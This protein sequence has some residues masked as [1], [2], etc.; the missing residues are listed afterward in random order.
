MT[1]WAKFVKINY[2][3]YKNFGKYLR[4]K[5]EAIIPK[6]ALNKFANNN[7]IEPAV[8]SRIETLKQDIKLGVLIK[9]A[10]GMG[11]RPSELLADYEKSDFSN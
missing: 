7:A 8:L 6:I 11:M 9:I 1:Y 5:R 10:N 4:V 3:Q 2:M